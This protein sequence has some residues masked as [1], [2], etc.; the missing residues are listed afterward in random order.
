LPLSPEKAAC[1]GLTG[2][3]TDLASSRLRLTSRR[4]QRR[5]KRKAF[6][7][8]LLHSRQTRRQHPAAQRGIFIKASVSNLQ[9]PRAYLG[10]EWRGL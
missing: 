2:R 9:P 1:E 6:I 7:E 10:R 3:S 4:L 8:P 5:K